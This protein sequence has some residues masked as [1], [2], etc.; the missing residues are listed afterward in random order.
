ML[1]EMIAKRRLASGD[2][3]LVVSTTLRETSVVLSRL[4][5]LADV[6]I[7]G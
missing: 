1:V 5:A 7:S 4:V 3:A 6:V 2:F